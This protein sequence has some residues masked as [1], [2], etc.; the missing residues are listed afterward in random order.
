[1]ELTTKILIYAHALLGGLG[2]VT[3]VISVWATK[4]N[5]THKKAGMV[6]SYAM[7]ASALIS[8]FVA[9]MPGHENLFL[10]LIGVFTLYMVL[11]GNRALNLKSKVK[12]KPNMMDYLLSGTMLLISA[13]MIIIG[14][15][16]IVQKANNSMLYIFFGGFG[17]LLTL[18]DFKTFNTFTKNKSVRL[19]SHSGRMIGAL[20]AATT[21]F[22]VTGLAIG[23]V[24]IW[25]LPT[26]IGTAY[27]LYWS[28]KLKKTESTN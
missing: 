13:V 14:L 11:A 9:R 4:G 3:G 27:I 2:L 15:I 7:V 22:M 19:R 16:G 21:A 28:R 8:L 6:F 5:R 23:T 1:M 25:I 10:F 18:Y 24:L 26:I 12:L 20:I 17:V